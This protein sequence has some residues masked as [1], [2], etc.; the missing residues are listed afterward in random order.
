MTT[1]TAL[2]AGAAPRAIVDRSTTLNIMMRGPSVTYSPSEGEAGP[3]S[4]DQAVEA[5]TPPTQG[6]EQPAEEPAAATDGDEEPEG[7]TSTPEDAEAEPETP[8]EGEEAEVEP[9]PVVAAEPPKY[10]SKDAKEA[11]ANLPADLQAVVLA[12]EGPRE[13]AA[14]KA[15][16]EAAAKVQ[17]ADAEVAKVQKLANELAEFLPQALETFASR[18]GSDPD[19]VAYAQEHGAE[20]M[21][22]AKAQ[23]D[24]ELTQLQKSVAAKQQADQIAQVAYVKAE[25]VKLAEVE[26]DLVPDVTDLNKGLDKRQGVVKFLLE[27]G[28]PR[29]TIPDI[30]AVEMSIAYDAMRWRDAQAKL[31]A[32]PPKPTPALRPAPVRPAAAQSQSPTVRSAT[33]AAGRFAKTRSVDDAVEL[34]LSRKA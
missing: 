12:Q 29:E 28:L 7:E 15:K 5:L 30:S 32:Q 34:L 19:W 8:A 23:H 21:T 22:I 10:W 33:T 4:F 31:K 18:W 25:F 26:P 6:D 3:M 2:C 9:E 17:A 14:S 27:K 11:F 1:K 20:A 16:A 24:A 13:E